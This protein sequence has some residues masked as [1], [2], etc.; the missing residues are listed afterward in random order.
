MAF[1][2][3]QHS[4]Y[5]RRSLHAVVQRDAA[6]QQL[7]ALIGQPVDTEA[8]N[9]LLTGFLA[10]YEAPVALRKTRQLVIMAL[11]EQDLAGSATLQGICSGMTNLAQVVT[12]SALKAAAEELRQD[13]GT[14]RNESGEPID[15]IAVAMGKAGANE[16]NVSSD[17]DLVFLIREEGETDGL[18]SAGNETRRGRIAASDFAHRMARRV[19]TL[20]SEPTEHGFVFRLDTRL[21]P[22]G[23][24]G[25][26]VCTFSALEVYFQ[27]QGRAWER[28]AWLKA[29]V[30]GS[31]PFAPAQQQAADAKALDEIIQ[32][33][34]FRR[35]HDYEALT[36]L[37]DVHE[38]IQKEAARREGQRDK[39]KD[40]KLGRGGIREIEFTA[41][42][43]QVIR[44]GRDRGLRDRST[45]ATLAALGERE[46]LTAEEVSGLTDAY[47][48]LRRCEHMVQYREDQQTHYLP[49]D[50]EQRAQVAEMMGCSLS[51]LDTAI[52]DACLQVS[53]L[54]DDLMHVPAGSAA[55]SDDPAPSLSEE[56]IEKLDDSIRAHVKSLVQGPK[57]RASQPDAQRA[58]DTLLLNAIDCSCSGS[59]I[60]RLI[61]LLET[62]C[63]RPAYLTF[64][65][66]Y[67]AAYVRVLDM[68]E[69]SEWASQYLIQHPILLDE[70]I[71][72]N[73]YEPTDLAQWE[74]SLNIEMQS[75]RSE[76]G[77]DVERQMNVAREWHHAQLFK[78]LAREL[79][80]KLSIQSVADELSAL[81]DHTLNVAIQTV[82]NELPTKFRDKPRVAAIAYGRLGGKELGYASDL[83]LVFLYDDDD[84]RAAHA[85][86]QLTRRVSSWLSTQT[87]A[88][89]LF[90]IDLRLRPDGDSGVLVS[91]VHGFKNY[92]LES[93]WVW[94]HQAL[95]RARFSAG[96]PQ[97]GE[98]F[99]ALRTE[100]LASPRDTE[101]L[102]NEVLSMRKKIDEGHPNKSA[103]FDLKHDR[104]GMVD[105]EFL[106]QYLVLA[107][108]HDQPGLIEN[109]GNIALLHRSAELGLIDQSMAT[110]VAN[111]YKRYRE[112][113]HLLR[114]QAASY[115]RV[116]PDTVADEV[117]S[118]KALWITLLESD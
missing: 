30:I 101:S 118:V 84:D 5:F 62:V 22:N 66:Q 93:A 107:N 70:L 113:Q 21:R 29:A 36:S 75:L 42:L 49:P 39:G 87:M 34:V 51:Q 71:D 63:R 24:S 96:D 67:P 25:P 47:H 8:I 27:V 60:Q 78:I 23:D 74:D 40:V 17:L 58:I 111:A 9:G 104:G 14:P 59:C 10:D 85:Y 94:E 1:L 86:S 89:T 98:Q 115:A 82:W 95:T 7:N 83:D 50:D 69:S 31:S 43:F 81:A 109:L 19:L 44:G 79:A 28:F 18:D 90:E 45:L 37:R 114:M 64:L 102:R 41:Q 72:G 15:L 32:P 33:F 46:L 6:L 11:M 97:V 48:L 61:K 3:E 103:L 56:S 105:I 112:L 92:Q 26:L 13:F 88:G 108:A 80:G 76:N 12:I 16:L 20:L 106:V 2:A 65:A 4:G 99:E 116:E 73:V 100:L 52:D 55:D 54:F 35:Y 57:Y 38:L 117:A 53:N 68:L 110:T 91:S 77:A